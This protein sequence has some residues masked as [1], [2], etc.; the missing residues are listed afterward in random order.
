M[1]FK[2]KRTLPSDTALPLLGVC[3]RE[4]KTHV[5]IELAHPS[6]SSTAHRSKNT[7][8]LSPAPDGKE[9]ASSPCS[10]V[11]FVGHSKEPKFHFMLAWMS[12]RAKRPR[13]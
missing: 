2:S 11:L 7:E 10:G 6:P 12:S 1:F 3:P 9:A 13:W 8:T 4:V 5:H